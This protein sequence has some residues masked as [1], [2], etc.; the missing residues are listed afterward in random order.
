MIFFIYIKNKKIVI[1]KKYIILCRKINLNLLLFFCYHSN[2]VLY[3]SV[4]TFIKLELYKKL[5]KYS[6]HN[7]RMGVVVWKKK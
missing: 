7:I 1:N 2:K 5:I 6:Y 3:N 4:I